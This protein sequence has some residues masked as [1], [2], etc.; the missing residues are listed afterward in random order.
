MYAK[1]DTS[2]IKITDFGVSRQ[3]IEDKLTLQGTLVGTPVYLS[4]ALW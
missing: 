1:K 4:P 2:D 3:L